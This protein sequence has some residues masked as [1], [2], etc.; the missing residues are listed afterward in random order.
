MKHAKTLLLALPAAALAVT[1]MASTAQAQLL[2]I[3]QGDAAVCY[4]DT[5]RGN[6]G[7]F[8]AIQTCSAALTQSNSHKDQ[9]AT[10]VNRGV[11]YMRKG[12]Q[13][14][15]TQ[16]YRRALKMMPE[17][18]EAHIN[19]AASLI[20]QEKFEEAILSLNA[21]LEDKDG[22]RRAEALY[23]RAIAFDWTDDYRGAYFDLKEALAL[24]PDWEPAVKL[25]SRY[26]VQPAG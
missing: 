14:R 1:A 10:Y 13:V 20:R 5:I 21:A 2:V 18:T 25:I 6:Q 3:G 4:Q 23:N 12:D 11:L 19:L 24:R 8:S 15:A 17:L 26:D 22:T 7:S 16:D 9:A